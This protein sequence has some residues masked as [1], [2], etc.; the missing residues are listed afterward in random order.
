VARHPQVREALLE[1]QRDFARSAPNGA[2]LD[3]RDIGT[4][5]LPDADVK[6][7]VTAAPE[8]RA[9]RRWLELQDA[10]KDRSFEEVLQAVK[11]RDAR[12]AARATAP[13]KPAADAHLLDTSELDICAAFRA[14]REIIDAHLKKAATGKQG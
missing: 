1:F 9:K 2:V 14:A 13:M 3:G 12:D 10:G 5:V 8:V 7:F 6:L 11:E 4:V